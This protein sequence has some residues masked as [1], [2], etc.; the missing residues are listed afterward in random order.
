M[1]GK[2]RDAQGRLM[3][4]FDSQQLLPGGMPMGE[5]TPFDFGFATGS[6][7]FIPFEGGVVVH[8]QVQARQ[9]CVVPAEG[10]PMV[11]M[12]FVLAG[13]YESGP[14]GGEVNTK[15]H[16]ETYNLLYLP[17]A[18][19]YYRFFQSKPVELLEICLEEDYFH[20]I[21]E[22]YKNVLLPF[23]EAIRQKHPYH[24]HPHALPLTSPLKQVLAQILHHL[25]GRPTQTMF[26]ESK[27]LELLCL[28]VQHK[29][30][31]EAQSGQVLL[32]DEDRRKLHEC[33]EIL[34]ARYRNPPT[35]AELAHMVGLNEFKLK[36]GF[37]QVFHQT[38]YR[39]LND[40]KMTRAKELLAQHGYPVVEVA[41]ELGFLH[42]GHFS[43]AFKKYYGISP[44]VVR[45]VK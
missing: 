11:K 38:V 40:Y 42:Q 41:H 45:S 23:Y 19:G 27:V 22:K 21:S 44:I 8:L 6:S 35:L 12:K 32:S 15:N 14:D 20:L 43:R 33:R 7:W 17:Q 2:L 18:K 1:E 29:Q 24:F 31:W 5:R 3:S 10:S 26:L 9:D 30:Q 13:E 4:H 16:G 34:L 25:P 39:Y 37:K 28:Q 36:R